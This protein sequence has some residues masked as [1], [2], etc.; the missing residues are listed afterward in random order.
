[1]RCGFSAEAKKS[2][3]AYV[4]TLDFHNETGAGQ[5]QATY[6]PLPCESHQYHSRVAAGG[7]HEDANGTLVSVA[8]APKPSCESC[9]AP[10]D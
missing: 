4:N 7:P 2:V 10:C 1:M 6:K 9:S 8:A 3:L 5:P